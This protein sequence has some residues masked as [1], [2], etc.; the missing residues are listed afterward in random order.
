M[1]GAYYFCAAYCL[2]EL[3]QRNVTQGAE[4]TPLA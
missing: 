4:H 2:Q 3:C 1:G